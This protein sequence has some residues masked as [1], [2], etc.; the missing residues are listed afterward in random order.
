MIFDGSPIINLNLEPNMP[1]K[2]PT[3]NPTNHAIMQSF[4]VV[5]NPLAKPSRY[6]LII[7]I[8]DTLQLV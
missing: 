7:S 6:V 4:K 3:I 8:I 2:V 1:N 5:S